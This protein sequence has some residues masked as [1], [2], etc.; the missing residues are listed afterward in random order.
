MNSQYCVFVL[1][2][3]ACAVALAATPV[4]EQPRAFGYVIGDVLEQRV[5]LPGP[6]ATTQLADLADV[7]RVSG[8]FVRLSAEPSDGADNLHWL[9]LKYQILNTAMETTTI[10]L[11]ALNLVLADS[12]QVVVERW[13]IAVSPLTP[14]DEV[15]GL[16]L[17]YPDRPPSVKL[18]SKTTNRFHI[19]VSA[20][21]A[22]LLAWLSWWLWR[23]YHD[24]RWLPFARARRDIKQ[25]STGNPDHNEQAWLILHHA[26]NAS[27]GVC[28]QAHSIDQLLVRCPWLASLREP[29]EAFYMAS[30]ARF[31]ARRDTD[32]DF[33]L[34]GFCD[35]LY[36][37]EKNNSTASG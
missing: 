26:I 3:M 33:S 4:V 19:S 35:A 9:T 27:A 10:T 15:D 34:S 12:S 29:I 14:R 31:F 22:C 20:L 17:L 11:P 2:L 13:P 1:L 28:I 37:A 24:A 8:W 30:A 5:G 32:P 18:S 25:L 7:E 23:E 6:L 16:P 36:R 21:I